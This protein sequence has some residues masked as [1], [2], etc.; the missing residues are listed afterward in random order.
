MNSRAG[1]RSSSLV[2]DGLMD[3]QM[4]FRAPS[5]YIMLNRFCF[6]MVLMLKA[7]SLTSAHFALRVAQYVEPGSELSFAHTKKKE[8]ICTYT[9]EFE[10]LLKYI[11]S[12][13]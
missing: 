1:A 8:A 6:C 9:F 2:V 3:F 7:P 11:H 5:T 12:R 13:Y 4:G 10:V